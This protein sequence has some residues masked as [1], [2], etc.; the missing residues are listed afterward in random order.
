M[1]VSKKTQKP[2]R[3]GKKIGNK[4]SFTTKQI[5][6]AAFSANLTQYQLV[7]LLEALEINKS[8][9]TLNP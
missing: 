1:S 9:T 2:I 8:K 6:N 7:K 4:D 3:Q 5:V